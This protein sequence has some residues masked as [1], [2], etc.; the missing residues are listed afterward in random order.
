[1]NLLTALTILQDRDWTLVHT[2]Y[3]GCIYTSATQHLVTPLKSVGSL[4]AG[5]LDTMFRPVHKLKGIACQC[6]SQKP[7]L[8]PAI[9][10]ILEK[11]GNQLWGRVEQQ[12][13]LLIAS[14]NTR[15][16]VAKK[17]NLQLAEFT[18]YLQTQSGEPSVFSDN[19]AFDFHHDITLVREL[20][21]QFKVNYLAEQTS[22]THELF[23]QFMT[24]KQY[25]STEQTQKI[26]TLIQQL[27]REM[28]NFSLL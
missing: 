19:F 16:M 28:L 18:T 1:M 22:I 9:S 3:S 27:G 4:P 14:G 26:E 25:P 20:F 8:L 10:V 5:T 11:Q 15:E 23:N 17:L 12:G 13:M 6:T 21:Q 7:T 24:N 2:G